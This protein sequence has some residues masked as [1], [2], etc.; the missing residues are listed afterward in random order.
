MCTVKVAPEHMGPISFVYRFNQL[1][2]KNPKTLLCNFEVYDK[3]GKYFELYT[4][5]SE[6]VKVPHETPKVVMYVSRN[7]KVR[8]IVTDYGRLRIISL[9]IEY[10]SKYWSVIY[11]TIFMEV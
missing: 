9:R 8:A 2:H 10:A 1:C 5:P 4:D 11:A 3:D 7:G 6:V